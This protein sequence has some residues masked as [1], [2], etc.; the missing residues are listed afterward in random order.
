MIEHWFCSDCINRKVDVVQDVAV[1]IFG[2]V[3]LASDR[4]T[5][6]ANV[7]LWHIVSVQHT[8]ANTIYLF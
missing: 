6:K 2:V 1:V 4:A 5:F 3:C 8:I 7:L